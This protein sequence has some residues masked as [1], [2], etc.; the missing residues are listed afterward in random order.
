VQGRIQ[1]RGLWLLCALVLACNP[2][3][4]AQSN[5]R[6]TRAVPLWS[7]KLKQQGFR[8]FRHGFVN[9][10][11]SQA[12]IAFS[13]DVFVAI[14][15]VE[16]EMQEDRT[17]DK[18]I[19]SGWRLVGLFW[20]RRTGELRAK[21]SWIADLHTELFSTASGN[22]V[23]RLDEF[24]GP[25][26]L[27][28]PR[29]SN[30]ILLSPNGEELRRISLPVRGKS[31]GEWW[32]VISSTSGKSILAVHFFE[33]EPREYVLL[34]AETFQR[35]ATWNSTE[36]RIHHVQA[37]SDEH[38][39]YLG[40][41]ANETFIGTADGH[42]N[43]IELPDGW[44]Q[45]LRDDLILTLSHRPWAVAITK[46]SGERFVSFELG[47]PDRDAMANRPFVSADGARF[48][49]VTTVRG[50]SKLYVWQAPESQPIFTIPVTYLTTQ[51]TEAVLSPD[52]LHVA[53]INNG[54]IFVYTLPASATPVSRDWAHSGALTPD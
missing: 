38:L 51:S 17:T 9:D 46:L 15:D 22:F 29:Q 2:T 31:K 30:L 27:D 43:R 50:Q 53:F 24:P 32:E 16:S 33:R 45:F 7:A 4:K 18:K 10:Y 40:L 36:K 54:A 44:K 25:L 28:E 14:F 47:L 26:R 19:W 13:T 21:R 11:G 5:G 34:D 37:I 42:L 3:I 35:R 23:L 8:T 39:L 20:D 48:G 52:G 12:A 49:T 6:T 41:G 1:N